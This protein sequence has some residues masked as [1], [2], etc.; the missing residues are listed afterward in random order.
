M[1]TSEMRIRAS[2]F[3]NGM[4]EIVTRRQAFDWL[5]LVKREEELQ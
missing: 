3:L 4:D 2:V 5:P 1:T